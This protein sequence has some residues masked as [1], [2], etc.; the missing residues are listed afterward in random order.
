MKEDLTP[1]HVF[2]KRGELFTTSIDVADKFGKQHAHVLRSVRAI[3]ENDAE[4]N[5]SDFGLVNFKETSYLDEKNERRPMYEMTRSGFSILA[6]G[7]TGKKALQWKIKYEQAFSKMET[8]LLNQKNLSWQANRQQGKLSRLEETDTI[9]LFTEYA[10]NQGSTKPHYYY[11]H[12]TNATYKALFIVTDKFPGSFRNL[13]DNSQ[14]SFL[15]TA[16]IVAGKA[17]QDGM[18]QG[19]FYK[20]IYLLAKARLEALAATIGQTKVITGSPQ[21][22]FQ[23]QIAA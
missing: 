22:P 14:L 7:F 20:D 19:L 10:A 16:E 8:A 4:L 15:A 18:S 11:K 13:L 1:I 9:K 2:Q 17:L 5:G 21:L 3:L 6:M 23:R 12:L